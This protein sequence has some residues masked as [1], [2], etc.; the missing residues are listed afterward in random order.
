MEKPYRDFRVRVMVTFDLDVHALSHTDA[1]EAAEDATSDV[2]AR[3]FHTA[4]QVI[5]DAREAH[6]IEP[7]RGTRRMS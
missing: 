3:D 1:I 7:V 6:P 2:F 4:Q 5:I